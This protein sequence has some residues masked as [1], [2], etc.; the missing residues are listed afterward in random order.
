MKS[1]GRSNLSRFKEIRTLA[2]LRDGVTI[3]AEV[4]GYLY[5]IITF[6]RLHRAVGSG[7]TPRAT[8]HFNHLVK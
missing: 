1:L 5:N 3:A 6:L 2:K 4:T 8:R 7:I